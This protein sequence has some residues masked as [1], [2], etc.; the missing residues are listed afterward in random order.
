MPRQPQNRVQSDRF[1]AAT[2]GSPAQW[3]EFV[4]DHPRRGKVEGKVF[5]GPALTLTG[6]EVSLPA[7]SPWPT[8]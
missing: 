5:L 8:W 4:H 2:Y 3:R 1:S 7:P 6:M